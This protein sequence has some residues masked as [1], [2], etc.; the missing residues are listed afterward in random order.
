[1][2]NMVVCFLAGIWV[3]V[4]AP[5]LSRTALGEFTGMV[6]G[7]EGTGLPGALITVRNLDGGSPILVAAGERGVYRASALPAGRYSL[8]AEL[9]GFEAKSV[10]DV[11]VGV[12]ETR[13][14]DFQLSLATLH[15]VVTVIGSSPRDS[16]EASRARETAARDVGEALEQN[17]AVWKIRKG[18][19]ASDVVL[20]GFQSDNVNVLID[21]QRVYG[22]CPNR[23]DPP[24]F[25]VDFS[26][27]DRV[28]MGK[29][30]FDIRN[31]GSLGGVVNIVTRKPADGLHS[32][33]N[34][35]S[36]SDGFVN[37]SLTVSYGRKGYAALAGY[38]YRTSNP[39]TDGSGRRFTEYGNYR[40][41]LYGSDAFRVDSGWIRLSAQ[42]AANQSVQFSYSRQNADHV[43]YPYLQ[44]DAVYD[45][46]DRAGLDYRID[47]L[48]D[49]VRS[50][51]FQTYFT[52][53]R[54][55][56]TDEFRTSSL[57][58]PRSY[59]MGTLA[60]T[61]AIGGRVEA[62]VQ[63]VTLGFET[64]QR[65]WAA[66]TELAGRG[67]SPQ[68][69]IPDVKT[70]SIGL[71]AE[72]TRLLTEALTLDAGLRLDR[73]ASEANSAQADTNLYQAYNS[74]RQTSAANVLPSATV[75]FDYRA[76]H[77][78]RLSAGIGH[79]VRMP[80]PRERYF[81]L[82]RMGSDWVGNPLLD[83]S[84]N[85]GADAALSFRWQG[86]LLTSD[87]YYNRVSD[88]ITVRNAS[89]INPVA[90]VMNSV[91]RSY[92]NVDARIYGGEWEAIYLITQ[93]F[94]FSSALSYVRGEQTPDPALNVHSSNLAE[95]PPLT[96]RS[97]LRYDTG[98]F[99][100]A[101]EG[102]FTGAQT[103]VDTDLLEQKTAGYGIAN[104][105][106]SANLGSFTLRG[107]VWNI[108]DRYFTEHLSYQRDPFRS[109]VRVAEPGRNLYVNLAYRY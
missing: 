62:A 61:R 39:Y 7:P 15:E 105:S 36:G 95:M 16:L 4:A 30:P 89:R 10:P 83:P 82:R 18:G 72:Y 57:N 32:D 17:P 14:L 106:A 98:R 97:S 102:V 43:L 107:G 1:M 66:T 96:S 90:G 49:S 12:G 25:H 26:E 88:F 27:V 21:G 92:A 52:R 2:A 85:T 44:M 70:N 45:D 37:P 67:Y 59:S 109:G 80:D 94:F 41:D 28:E 53:V 40:P 38:S 77:G 50:I 47:D 86:L 6:V 99:A 79:T 51:R 91:A 108:L 65:S 35:S 69:S 22:A 34:F 104:L 93:R 56:M 48:S 33:L 60:E 87:L 75:R 76:P 3:G 68:F 103:R 8:K 74:T 63:D 84:K 55:W 19:I 29:G 101:L 42:P 11:A 46:T 71:Y 64:F 81:A 24:A 58:A 5:A 23:M 9:P 13:K 78:I 31:Q 20:R 100:V 54:H 73:A